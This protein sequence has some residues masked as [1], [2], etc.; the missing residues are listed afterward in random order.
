MKSIEEL[1]TEIDYIDVELS[2]LFVARMELCEEIGKIKAAKNKPVEVS[3]REKEII[4]YEE[5]GAQ[6]GNNNAI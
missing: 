2:R 3:S 6:N 5:R 4:G 1:R